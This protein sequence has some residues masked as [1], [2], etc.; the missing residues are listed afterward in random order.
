MNLLEAAL[1][2]AADDLRR[3][4]QPWAL[5]GGF[6]VSAR[7]EP[8]FTRDVDV[9]AA[10]GDDAEAEALVRWL[11]G[12]GYRLLAS[13]EH[14]A[15]ERLATVR[16]GSPVDSDDGVI[17]DVLFASSGI[18]PEIVE[19]AEQVEIIPGLI[20]PIAATGHL[21]ALKVLARDDETRPQDLA[22]LRALLTVATA[23]DIVV[24]RDAIRMI[25]DRGFA[26]GRD[27][28]AALAALKT[29]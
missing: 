10:V 3:Y 26:R 19:A 16:L 8:R 18:E 11:L 20:L 24:A 5:V 29:D 23:E 1:R 25:T 28:L 27:L 14:D 15:T 21:I 9:T 4:R 17:V 22:D 12:E 13:M 7:S 2:R 6:A